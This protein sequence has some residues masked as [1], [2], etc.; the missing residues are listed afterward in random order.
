MAVVHR[1]NRSRPLWVDLLELAVAHVDEFAG[2]VFVRPPPKPGAAAGPAGPFPLCFSWQVVNR[3]A[4][5]RMVS[6]CCTAGV[7]PIAKRLG[8][9]M[10]DVNHRVA[11]FKFIWPRVARFA[12]HC[13]R[14]MFPNRSRIVRVTAAVLFTVRLVI[15][16]F[17]KSAK[18]FDRR[19][20]LAQIERPSEPNRMLRLIK[21]AV[22]MSR[23]ILGRAHQKHTRWT[24]PKGDSLAIGDFQ[25]ETRPLGKNFLLS[26]GLLGV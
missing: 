4:R 17:D 20:V 26:F 13:A 19:F 23:L 1:H 25:R 15:L 3:S 8:I 14:P 18:L 7:Q 12:P 24:Q 9:R 2:F 16:R 5:R 21:R 22:A 11:I 10:A 6:L